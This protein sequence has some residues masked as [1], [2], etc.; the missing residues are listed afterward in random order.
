MD[1]AFILGPEDIPLCPKHGIRLATD[2]FEHDDG[3]P[4]Y[5]LGF[6]PLCKLHYCFELTE[7]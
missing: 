3:T 2:Y 1:K 5:E 6:C 7:D 4:A